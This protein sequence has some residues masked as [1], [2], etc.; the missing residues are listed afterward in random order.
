MNISLL[1]RIKFLS[2]SITLLG[3]LFTN[4]YGEDSNIKIEEKKISFLIKS[5]RESKITFIRNG[6]EHTSER[7]ADHLQFKYTRASKMFWFF[8]PKTK[9]TAKNFI[10]KIASKS[11]T[12]GK[13]YQV[14]LKDGTVMTTEKWLNIKLKEFQ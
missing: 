1:F 2:I 5:V 8:G 14:R 12:T 10:E 4:I 6:E 7:A 9:I 3:L 13:A 11:S